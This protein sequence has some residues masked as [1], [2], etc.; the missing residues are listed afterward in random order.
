[1]P[2]RTAIVLVSSVC[3]LFFGCS[4]LEQLGLSRPTAHITGVQFAD[5]S[6]SSA[7]LVFDVK[8]DNPYAVPLPL[9][10]LNYSLSSGTTSLLS[11]NA[12]P[13][14]SIPAKSKQSVSLPVT[15]NYLDI[16]KSVK[17][18]RPGMTIPYKAGLDLSV[19]TPSVGPLTLPLKK[20]GQL[21]LPQVSGSGI[22][23]M[24]NTMKDATK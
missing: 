12:K 18:I 10:N 14:T 8:V 16:F 9:T 6:L 20:E 1:M 11:G 19:N 4:T 3:F 22:I 17:D 5:A 24:L 7:H 23:D 2:T 15:V 21:A 13:Q